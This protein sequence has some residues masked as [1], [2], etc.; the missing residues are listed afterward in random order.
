VRLLVAEDETDIQF[1]YEAWFTREGFDVTIVPDGEAALS[2]VGTD[3]FD[4][5]ILDV[6]M[7]KLDGLEVCRRIRQAGHS[8][9]PIIIVSAL[10]R[11]ADVSAGMEAG[12]DAYV[13][14]PITPGTVVARIRE[15]VA[16]RA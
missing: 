1:L 14:K 5:I 10:A 8:D 12:A 15:I 16:G 9:V 7:P 6:M 11:P 3:H 13:D 4:C 2:A